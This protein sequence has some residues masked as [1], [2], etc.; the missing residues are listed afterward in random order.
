[1][2]TKRCG[3]P[4]SV[5]PEILQYQPYSFP[6]DIWSFGVLLYSLQTGC[7]PFPEL[8]VKLS[9]TNKVTISETISMELKLN[10]V[11]HK[12]K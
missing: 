3:T 7:L 1:M 10:F 8:A 11:N 4:G 5:A 6:A 2:A 9:H 12:G